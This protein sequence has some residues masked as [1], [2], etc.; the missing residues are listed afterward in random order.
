MMNLRL[1]LI[2]LFT[3]F[4]SIATMSGQ[5]HDGLIPITDSAFVSQNLDLSTFHPIPANRGAYSPVF[6]YN[7]LGYV[8]KLWNE[9]SLYYHLWYLPIAD[10]LPTAAFH[11]ELPRDSLGHDGPFCWDPQNS[12]L[13]FTRNNE[14]KQRG[15][16]DEE[17][18]IPLN[19]YQSHSPSPNEFY[20]PKALPFNDDE[21]SYCHPSFDSKNDRL[22]FASD[23]PGGFGGMDL[24]EVYKI[25]DSWSEP[26]NLGHEV[27]SEANDIFPFIHLGGCLF[28][29][30]DRVE[31][32]GLDIY[33]SPELNGNFEVS[34]LLPEPFNSIYDDFGITIDPMATKG[35]IS[36]NRGGNNQPDRIYEFQSILPLLPDLKSDLSV[37]IIVRDNTTGLAVEGAEVGLF[38]YDSEL[39]TGDQGLLNATFSPDDQ[40]NVVLRYLFDREKAAEFLKS[41]DTNGKSDWVLEFADRYLI[42]AWHEAYVLKQYV[43]LRQSMTNDGVM[44]IFLEPDRLTEINVRFFETNTR[45]LSNLEFFITGLAGED[46]KY[47]EL[48]ETSGL[49]INLLENRDYRLTAIK[50]GYK[51]KNHI[52]NLSKWE[53]EGELRITLQKESLNSGEN[54]L[55]E[56][57]PMLVLDQILYDYNDTRIKGDYAFELDILADMMKQFPDIIVE[58][59]AHTDSRGETDYNQ[60]LSERRAKAAMDYLVGR[61]VDPT[62]IITVGYGES[63]P[64]NHC[65]DGVVCSETEYQYNRRTEVRI[66]EG[67]ADFSD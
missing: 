39:I 17:I 46:S 58:L 48:T 2:G 23:R 43:G 60:Q 63:R 10:G 52:F 50:D 29:A 9:K 51:V 16:F 18:K 28:Y 47:Y 11:L 62:H 33:L 57:E 37:S 55:V 30:S 34:K 36:S 32:N 15:I 45:P 42:Y 40:G 21:W 6:I 4:I 7:G 67:K 5:V 3:I 14:T 25:G 27:N 24:Y 59:A 49:K 64:R 56:E 41:T 13:F 44:E 8:A 54:T 12:E 20:T 53:V 1:Y 22:I 61:G 65:V 38:A 66:L 19:I 26:V 35:Y 31:A